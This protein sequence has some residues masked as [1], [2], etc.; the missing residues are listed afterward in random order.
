MPSRNMHQNHITLLEVRN[1]EV[2]SV[3]LKHAKDQAEH[4]LD[5]VYSAETRMVQIELSQHQRTI[6]RSKCSPGKCYCSCH[7]SLTIS[8]KLWTLRVPHDWN[9]CDNKKCH[10]YKHTSLWFS[11][12]S[13]GIP[14]AIR[15]S[16]D[17]LWTF[18]QS[19]ISPS[20]QVTRVVDWNS[21][22]FALLVD[23]K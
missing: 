20:L 10:N 1:T 15:A 22:A 14:Y 8:G 17:V 23:I 3:P 19:Y 11:L 6:Q 4:R 9:P 2:E 21:P 7:N 16:L 5:I 18:N 13:I 12:T